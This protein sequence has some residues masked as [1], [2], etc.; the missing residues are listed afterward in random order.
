VEC[1][2]IS[3]APYIVVKTS[4]EHNL[5]AFKVMIGVL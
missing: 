3:G 1:G 2:Q 5:A 4:S